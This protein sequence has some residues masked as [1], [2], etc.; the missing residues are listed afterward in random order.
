MIMQCPYCKTE[1]FL[2]G[3]L[4]RHLPRYGISAENFPCNKC[5]EWLTTKIETK[6]DIQ[7]LTLKKRDKK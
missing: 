7:I 2:P 4:I 3:E 1:S 6:L 5:G